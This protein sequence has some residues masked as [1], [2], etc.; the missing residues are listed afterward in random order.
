VDYECFSD[1]IN[2]KNCAD[3]ITSVHGARLVNTKS[4]EEVNF[5]EESL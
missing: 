1:V 3:A 2:S 4:T 5:I